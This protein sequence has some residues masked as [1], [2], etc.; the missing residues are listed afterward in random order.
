MHTHCNSLQVSVTRSISVVLV[1]RTDGLRN[2]YI[3]IYARTVLIV[4]KK[5]P[6]N[7]IVDLPETVQFRRIS[8]TPTTSNDLIKKLT[9]IELSQIKV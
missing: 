1:W 3:Y 4:L 7:F 8:G 6:L 9:N 5:Q 2:G